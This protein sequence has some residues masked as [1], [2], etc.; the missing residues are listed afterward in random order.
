MAEDARQTNLVNP[1][2]PPLPVQAYPPVDV[3]AASYYSLP[4]P[5]LLATRPLP[6]TT[7]LATTRPL[8]QTTRLA[9][10]SLATTSLATT[11]LATSSLRHNR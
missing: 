11:R 8:P 1:C 4:T 3:G 7:H 9:S 10:T 5:L 6:Q 2:P